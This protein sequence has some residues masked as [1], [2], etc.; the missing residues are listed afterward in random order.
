MS[1]T[2][3]MGDAGV[4]FFD[5][6][7]DFSLCHA[8]NTKPQT[9]S[10]YRISPIQYMINA[11]SDVTDSKADFEVQCLHTKQAISRIKLRSHCP[12]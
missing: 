11:H 10:E 2:V 1:I 5:R 8:W 12:L 3:L 6:S 9:R 4:V 7:Y